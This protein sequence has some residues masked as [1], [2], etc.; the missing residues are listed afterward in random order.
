MNWMKVASVAKILAAVAVATIAT[1]SSDKY[2]DK[3]FNS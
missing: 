2:L 1:L 3:L